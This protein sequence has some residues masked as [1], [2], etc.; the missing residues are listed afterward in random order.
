MTAVA[1]KRLNRLLPALVLQAVCCMSC[2]WEVPTS[3]AVREGPTFEFAGSGRLARFTV[4]APKRGRR[5]SSSSPEMGIAIWQ[6]VTSKG[7]FEG[8]RVEGMR[9]TYGQIPEGYEQTVPRPSEKAEPPPLRVV[10]SFFAETTNA[11]GVGG[12]IFMSPTGPVQ[13]D[14]PDQCL[15]RIDGREV[16]VNCRT[17]EPYQEPAD[18][19]KFVQEHR[20]RR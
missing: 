6:I 18:L 3:V 13:I 2:E 20:V 11:P 5:I 16:E 15:R 10:C 7:Y 14:V 17:N 4:Y 9:V 1:L 12:S 8:A 19:E